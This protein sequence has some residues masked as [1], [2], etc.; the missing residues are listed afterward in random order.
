MTLTSLLPATISSHFLYDVSGS[1]CPLL[2]NV[3][4]RSPKYL[5]QILVCSG[6]SL[7]VIYLAS[8]RYIKGLLPTEDTDLPYICVRW[9]VY[10]LHPQ[11]S[12]ASDH[13]IWWVEAL[14]S[15]VQAWF[16]QFHSWFSPPCPCSYRPSMWWW[17]GVHV[18]VGCVGQDPVS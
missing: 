16:D 14:T 17:C 3:I 7:Y 2:T 5:T 10:H 6:W 8:I 15:F 4:A 18:H 12:L 11:T 9:P 1:E 13:L